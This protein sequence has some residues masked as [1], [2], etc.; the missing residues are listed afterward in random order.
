M[1]SH[2]K[3][4]AIRTTLLF[5]L[6]FLFEGCA[7]VLVPADPSAMRGDNNRVVLTLGAMDSRA[8]PPASNTFFFTDELFWNVGNERALEVDH[9]TLTFY[10]VNPNDPTSR[11][12]LHF[13]C[14]ITSWNRHVTNRN[15]VKLTVIQ[16][17]DVGAVI[18]T[19]D[20]GSIFLRHINGDNYTRNEHYNFD[21]E[22]GP[23]FGHTAKVEL[24]ATG[25]MPHG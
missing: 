15:G 14:Q 24:S 16:K 25:E 17:N 19:L 8:V 9:A 22:A 11:F 5:S 21:L 2:Q 12:K 3:V 20:V 7:S 10:P 6:T 18:G 1:N 4:G 13:H 23:D